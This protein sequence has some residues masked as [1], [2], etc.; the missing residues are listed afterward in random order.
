MAS[1]AASVVESNAPCVPMNT[2]STYCFSCMLHSVVVYAIVAQFLLI[3]PW[4]GVL[5]FKVPSLQM[6]P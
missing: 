4:V 6:C 2:A 1:L 5:G 3:S